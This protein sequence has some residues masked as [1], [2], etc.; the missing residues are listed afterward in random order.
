MQG[1]FIGTDVTGTADLGNSGS[2]IRLDAPNNI[3]GGRTPEARNIISGNESGMRIEGE[4]N[5]VQGNFIGTDVTGTADLGNF[6]YGVLLADVDD[7]TIGGAMDGA[8]NVIAFNGY[9]GV[10]V[11][12]TSNAVFGTS[13]AI[14]SNS[15][16]AN[17]DLGI[18][19]KPDGVTPNDP[20]DSDAGANN[21]QNFPVLTS[22]TT[23]GSTIIE[24]MLNS[25]PNTEFNL[26]FFS[27]SACDPSGQGEGETLLGST[28]VATDVSGDVSFAVTFPV[29][30]PP[31][32]FISATATDPN[33]NTS[34]FSQCVEVIAQVQP[35]VASI[36]LKPDT[37]N[38]KSKGKWITCYIEL[39]EDYDVE[40]ID[41]ST[42]ELSYGEGS[43]LAA[44]GNIQDDVLMVKFDR[45][46]VQDMLDPGDD[47]E[48]MVSGELIDSTPFEGTD[49]IRVKN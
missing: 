16:F 2:G 49:T 31:G 22:A 4:G 25:T 26:E 9:A 27:N 45:S 43:V 20:G 7:T 10:T 5:L 17:T 46:D 29:T 35:V 13:N 41:M 33:N 21:L 44:W 23:D 28:D 1:N 15:I 36:D 37:L 40:D 39:P 12:G 18:D 48:I 3:V 38:L 34:E 6:G 14:L 42:I 8:G 19:L 32:E 11:S 24:G 47:I 30:V